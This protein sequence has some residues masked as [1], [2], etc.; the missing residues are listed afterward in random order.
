MKTLRII[1]NFVLKIASLIVPILS[2][3]KKPP[4][5]PSDEEMPDK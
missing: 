5:D 1:L 3:A 4:Q 2:K